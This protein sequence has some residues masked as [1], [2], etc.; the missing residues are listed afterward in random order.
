MKGTEKIIAHIQADAKAEAD[1]ILA[2]AEQ[3]CAKIREDFEAKA[4]DA[5]AEKIRAGV[6]ECEELADSKARIA[7]MESKKNILA[8]KQE[9]VSKGFGRAQE[10][11]LALPKEQYQAFLTKLVVKAASDGKGEVILNEKDR[12]AYGEAVVKAANAELGGSLT[13]SETVG[14]FA[15]GVKVKNGDVE[16]NNTL[17]L[18]IDLSRSDM[19]ANVAKALFG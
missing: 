2:Q 7:Q 8:L 3:Q 9:L 19:A 4:N 13:L 18:L 14:D 6:K 10:L 5:Y 12:A 11:I 16:G 17:E 1:A 15:G